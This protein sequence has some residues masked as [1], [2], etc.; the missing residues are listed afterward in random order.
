MTTHSLQTTHTF[1]C[2]TQNYISTPCRHKILLFWISLSVKESYEIKRNVLFRYVFSFF[3]DMFITQ[4]LPLSESGLQPCSFFSQCDVGL[5]QVW[6]E[7]LSL[8]KHNQFMPIYKSPIEKHINVL[9]YTAVFK[10]V[11]FF[12]FKIEKMYGWL[13][14]AESVQLF[15]FS[16]ANIFSTSTENDHFNSQTVCDWDAESE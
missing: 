9:Y 15:F 6:D 14:F 8:S 3:G 4:K 11:Y 12:G 1:L 16:E 5:G 10:I 2:N 13:V 7:N